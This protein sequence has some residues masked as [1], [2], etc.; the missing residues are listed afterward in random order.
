MASS[1]IPAFMLALYI[2]IAPLAMGESAVSLTSILSCRLLSQIFR[3]LCET[4][5]RSNLVAVQEPLCPLPWR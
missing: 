3:V 2:F 5:R 1:A 4:E